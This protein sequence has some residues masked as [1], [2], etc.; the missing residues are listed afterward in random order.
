MFN[1]NRYNE[2]FYASTVLE[3]DDAL[4]ERLSSNT[5]SSTSTDSST[6]ITSVFNYNYKGIPLLYSTITPGAYELT[7]KAEL[8]KEEADSNVI[9]EP[10]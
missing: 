6:N 7:E 4:A 1:I 2:Q 8:M 10:H 9:I 3:G 5:D